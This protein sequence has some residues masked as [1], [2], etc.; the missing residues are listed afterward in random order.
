MMVAPSDGLR[1]LRGLQL[2]PALSRSIL[3]SDADGGERER[4]RER[5]KETT[6][7]VGRLFSAWG[8]RERGIGIGRE[9]VR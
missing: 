7:A 5:E 4:E 2:Q 6:A 8:E 9:R 3:R 1:Q